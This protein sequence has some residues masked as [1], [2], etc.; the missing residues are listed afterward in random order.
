MR[1][2]K[3]S[4]G[5]G[6]TNVDVSKVI[7]YAPLTNLGCEFEFAKMVVPIAASGGS[8]TVQTQSHDKI[9]TTNRPLADLSIPN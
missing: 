2:L 8:A 1:Q 4:D 5:A 9:V 7:Y 3:D 6:S